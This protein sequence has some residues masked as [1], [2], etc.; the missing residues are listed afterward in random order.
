M[1]A[2]PSKLP[3]QKD[4]AKMELTS[5]E[6]DALLGRIEAD[7]ARQLKDRPRRLEHSHRV[8]ETAVKL[9]QIYG[10]DE[11]D[12]RAAGLLHDHAKAYSSEELLG[13]ARAFGLDFG[14]DLAL[15]L[16]ILHGPIAA[17]ELKGIYPELDPA[18]FDA[19]ERHTVACPAMSSL[20]MIIYIADGLE[21]G[22]PST[23]RIER[24]RALIGAISL[25]E[26][27]LESFAGS[28]AY[29]L[30]TKRFLWPGIVETYNHYVQKRTR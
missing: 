1:W 17:C 20:D 23:P 10:V 2:M 12:A 3:M 15:V 25:E 18:V 11:F 28:I 19:I 8:A 4:R 13:K 29:V 14:C 22:R 27:F 5:D 9:A 21:P 6:R 7:I 24:Q 26:L 16:P 30:E